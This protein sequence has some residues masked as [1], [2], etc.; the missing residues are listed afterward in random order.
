MANT[1]ILKRKSTTGAPTAGQLQ[2]GELAINLLDEKLYSKNS[3]NAIFEI[4]DHDNLTNY[5]AN[6][7]IDWTN[8]TSSLLTTGAIQAHRSGASLLITGRFRNDNDAGGS[9]LQSIGNG[10]GDGYIFVGQSAT[11]GGGVAY[12]GDATSPKAMTGAGTDRVTFFNRNADV[13]EE[14]FSYPYNGT[15]VRFRG[16]VDA[17]AG[18]DVTGNI[19]VTGTVDG[20]DVSTLTSNTGTVTSVTAGNG[21]DFT[22]ITATGAVTMG[23]PGTLTAA[24]TNAVTATSHTHDISTSGSGSILA[25]SGATLTGQLN[26]ADQLF[27]RPEIKDYAV[28][29]TTATVSANAVT[30]DCTNGNSF[31]I[32]MDPATANVTLTLSNPPASGNYG[33]V[34][35]LIQQGT[36]A[37]QITWP[38]SV[39]WLLGGAPTL[40]STNDDYDVVH[41]FTV[42]GGTTWFGTYALSSATGG[43]NVSNTGTPLNDQIAVWTASSIIEGTSGLTYNGSTLSVTGDVSGTTIG[44]ITQANLVDKTATETVSGTWN[45]T[46]TPTVSGGKVMYDQGSLNGVDLDTIDATN[47]EGWY[48]WTTTATNSPFNYG[49][50]LALHDGGQVI[51]CAF[52]NSTTGKMSIRRKDSGVWYAWTNF[53]SIDQGHTPVSNRVALWHTATEQDSSANLTFD[54]SLLNVIGNVTSTGDMTADN[55]EATGVGPN[56]TPG[57]D[58][59]YF[60]GYGVLGDRASPV[61]VSNVTGP[62]ALNYNGVHG[63]NTKL[64]T[65]ATGISVTGNIAVTGT[66]DGVDIAALDAAVAKTADNE[67]ISGDWTF[68][69]DTGNTFITM[70]KT[71]ATNFAGTYYNNELGVTRWLMVAGA[72]TDD[73]F[74]LY[75]YTDA[76]A[77]QGTALQIDGVTGQIDLNYASSATKL[78][79][80]TGGIDV[81]GNITVTGTVDGKDVSTLTSNTGTVTSVSAGNGMS[82]TTITGTGSVTMG[83]PGTLTAATSNGVTATSHTHAITTTGSGNIMA[84]NGATLTGALNCADQNV[85]RAKLDDYSIASGSATISANAATLTYSTAQAWELDLEAA[86]GNVTVTLSGGPPASTYGEMIVKVQQ[87][88]TAARTITWAGG[89]FEWPGGTAPTMTATADAI[90]IYHF[91]TWN[92]GTTWWGSVIQDCK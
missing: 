43:G 92:G 9:E 60:G 65:A 74:A 12:R 90:D 72:T 28:T 67:S 89:T 62:V 32:D 39:S 15:T 86:T 2:Q 70:Q 47:E 51:Q 25:S 19:T 91:S 14:V 84:S 61:Y 40:T 8:T 38:G 83:T 48:T 52:G 17:N 42:N 24:T 44:G 33:E 41:L 71:T 36:P 75:R 88:T 35:L 64:Q 20:K 21:M 80:V 77:F 54:G 57:T 66:V 23:T 29:H 30:V 31:F 79:I 56:S 18:L 13:D 55:F 58:D 63:T 37:Y 26:A 50:M 5:V 87:D 3:S 59:A 78:S 4:T 11:Y 34:N 6:E 10:Q 1:I 53:V 46:A 7:H 68:E 76:G 45:Y 85:D 81:T 73:D 82:F 69:A 27:I 16:N 49:A 22:S